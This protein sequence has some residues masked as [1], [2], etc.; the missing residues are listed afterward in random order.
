MQQPIRFGDRL[1]ELRIQARKTMGEVAGK[2]DVS[3]VYF[4]DVERGRRNPFPIETTDYKLLARMVGGDAEELKAL[5]STEREKVQFKCTVADAA[6]REKAMAL[7]RRLDDTSL[8]AEDIQA[9]LEAL[10]QRRER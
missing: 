7:A 3:I 10:G 6:V 1:R 8:S 2:L 5:A 4:S 9:A